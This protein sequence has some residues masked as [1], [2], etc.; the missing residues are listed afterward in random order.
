MMQGKCI[1]PSFVVQRIQNKIESIWITNSKK[2]LWEREEILTW[3]VPKEMDPGDM[4]EQQMKKRPLWKRYNKVKKLSQT[5][6]G[7]DTTRSQLSQT[8]LVSLYHYVTHV[9]NIQQGH[10]CH[11][12]HMPSFSFFLPLNKITIDIS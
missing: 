11:K 3:Y 10:N 9:E 1:I 5:S 8:F 12:P 4:D 2:L 7:K 6:H